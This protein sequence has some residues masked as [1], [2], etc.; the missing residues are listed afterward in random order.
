LVIAI[1]INY[2]IIITQDYTADKAK[3]L[4]NYVI[5]QD[6]RRRWWTYNLWHPAGANHMVIRISQAA[7]QQRRSAHP[8]QGAEST[9]YKSGQPAMG[10]LL[11]ELQA[12]QGHVCRSHDWAFRHATLAATKKDVRALVSSWRGG[13][14]RCVSAQTVMPCSSNPQ[15][16]ELV[17]HRQGGTEG[18]SSWRGPVALA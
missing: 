1:L 9:P 10:A 11:A 4:I 16:F 6:Y 12:G 15:V 14:C 13:V 17:G 8:L 5:T 2:V 18:T 3:F 7:C